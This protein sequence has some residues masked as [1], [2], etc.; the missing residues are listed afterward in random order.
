MM[1]TELQMQGFSSLER[2]RQF[3]RRGDISSA[4]E[5]YEKVFDPNA[6]DE[7]EARNMLIEA[8]SHL[9]RKHLLEAL[10]SF[11]E[12]LLMGTEVQ[13]RQALEGVSTVGELR[14]QV[15]R[16]TGQLKKTLKQLLGKRPPASLGISLISDEE[17]IVLISREA[18]EKLP[19]TLAKSGKLQ[20]LP[21]HL[22]DYALP[23]P[24]DVCVS[25]TDESDIRYVL[26]VV[27]H[28]SSQ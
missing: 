28:L 4:L 15:N 22:A 19:A 5:H 1:E 12:A 10:E 7:S 16:L 21:P 17:N 14:S 26:D 2:G 25:Y 9:S 8:R 13:R 6:L 24:T 20:R 3:L 27:R 18:L 11:E 23:L